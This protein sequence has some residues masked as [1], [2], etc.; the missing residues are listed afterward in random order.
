MF[1]KMFSVKASF[2]N[3]IFTKQLLYLCEINKK[4]VKV[5]SVK[6][7][8]LIVEIKHSLHEEKVRTQKPFNHRRSICSVSRVNLMESEVPQ[9]PD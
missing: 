5:H 2:K 6:G 1:E 4:G 3:T 8:S 7:S 9:N